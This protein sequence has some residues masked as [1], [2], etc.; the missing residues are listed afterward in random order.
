MCTSDSVS[1][2]MSNFRVLV[3]S[4]VSV[5][6]PAVLRQFREIRAT[7]AEESATDAAAAAAD[8]IDG[9]VSRLLLLLLLLA[10]SSLGPSALHMFGFFA[11]FVESALRNATPL[12]NKGLRT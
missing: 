6:F 10:V 2:N 12:L 4:H 5:P 11:F 1:P 3:R 9:G 7:S 8:E